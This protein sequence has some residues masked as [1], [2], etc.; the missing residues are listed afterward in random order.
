MRMS[1]G[2]LARRCGMSLM[3]IRRYESGER[4][5]RIEDL[6]KIASALHV[7]ISNLI[8]EDSNATMSERQKLIQ[9][10]SNR[11]QELDEAKLKE[12]NSYL[13]YLLQKV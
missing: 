2:E 4:S 12:L 9:E 3:S 13:Q 6:E 10:I 5:T 11:L 1:Q 7:P 8:D